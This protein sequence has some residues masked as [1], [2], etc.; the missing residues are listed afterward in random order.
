M[1]ADKS[2]VKLLTSASGPLPPC[3]SFRKRSD[4]RVSRVWISIGW[5]SKE[6]RPR[7]ACDCACRLRQSGMAG[8]IPAISRMDFNDLP[9]R[10]RLG[11]AAID[12]RARAFVSDVIHQHSVRAK[13]HQRYAHSN[14]LGLV[15]QPRRSSVSHPGSAPK[16]VTTRKKLLTACIRQFWPGLALPT[17][18]KPSVPVPPADGHSR[19]RRGCPSKTLAKLVNYP[20]GKSARAEDKSRPDTRRGSEVPK[21]RPTDRRSA[22]TFYVKNKR[23]GQGTATA[24]RDAGLA[25]RS[26][27]VKRR[28][29]HGSLPAAV[30]SSGG[31]PGFFAN[32]WPIG[33]PARKTGRSYS[34]N[35]CATLWISP[36]HSP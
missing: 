1:A 26:I 29:A 27:W 11:K 13:Q 9:T 2:P 12:R 28:G 14:E 18:G 3:S 15:Q 10:S 35:R 20:F 8:C 32:G 4:P 36:L 22:I 33:R 17:S 19:L 21:A 30:G 6:L 31:A 24:L 25:L 16:A 34:Q 7:Q 23:F 5:L